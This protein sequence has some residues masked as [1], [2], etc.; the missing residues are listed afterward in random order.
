MSVLELVETHPAHLTP[1]MAGAHDSLSK[2]PAIVFDHHDDLVDQVIAKVGKKI[3][4]GLPLAIGKPI[5]FV[6]AIYQRAKKDPSISLTIETGI[7]L[8]KPTGKSFLEK[9][10]LGP[11]VEREFADV[12]ISSTCKISEVAICLIMSLS[13]SFS[14]KQEAAYILN[15][16]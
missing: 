13:V 16:S 11:F 12:P 8:E 3:I 10:F 14:L 2:S 9:Q 1:L 6:N 15:S 4:L 5:S 7:T